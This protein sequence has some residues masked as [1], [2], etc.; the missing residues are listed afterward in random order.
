MKPTIRSSVLIGELD[1][2][3]HRPR[4]HLAYAP[5]EDYL[6]SRPLVDFDDETR[7]IR[8]ETDKL[9]K[10]IY[11]SVPHPRTSTPFQLLPYSGNY[12]EKRISPL[13]HNSMVDDILSMS[14]YSEP[15]SRTI[16]RGHLACVSYAGGRGYPRRKHL[17]SDEYRD[18]GDEIRTRS[19]YNNNYNRAYVDAMSLPTGFASYLLRIKP[20]EKN[21]LTNLEKMHL[22]ALSEERKKNAQNTKSVDDLITEKIR[23]RPAQ[24]AY[25]RSS[26]SIPLL[27]ETT[28]PSSVTKT[29]K[30]EYTKE[31]PKEEIKKEQP[32]YETQTAVPEVYKD[33]NLLNSENISRNT[34]PDTSSLIENKEAEVEYEKPVDPPKP[35]KKEKKPKKSILSKTPSVSDS[36]PPPAEEIKLKSEEITPS[37]ETPVENSKLEETPIPA[38][39]LEPDVE[40]A[41]VEQIEIEPKEPEATKSEI[42]DQEQEQIASLVES[43]TANESQP[44]QAETIT[45]ETPIT[46]TVSAQEETKAE[47]TTEETEPVDSQE[48]PDITVP[49]KIDEPD[50]QPPESLPEKVEE[51]ATEETQ[52]QLDQSES[53]EI[54]Q[55]ARL[56]NT[57]L[58][59]ASDTTIDAEKEQ[60]EN[61]PEHS[62]QSDL[63]QAPEEIIETTPAPAPEAADTETTPAETSTFSE[64][65]SEK[66][67]AKDEPKGE[68]N[69]T[70]LRHSESNEIQ[71]VIEDVTDLGTC[72]AQKEN[73]SEPLIEEPQ[74]PD[75]L[76]NPPEKESS[77][78]ITEVLSDVAEES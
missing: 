74:S 27:R 73:E 34:E 40:P 49:D 35:E 25:Q 12:T 39:D 5:L 1:R 67:E 29:R 72:D 23:D 48:N 44:S 24:K 41:K 54:L 37:E 55:E 38:K 42:A 78:V 64:T 56:D 16:G 47:I 31:E 45:E 13:G 61:I 69:E 58:A 18:I 30:D 28:K 7:L 70:S 17:F 52:P 71:N 77:N 51:V 57:D 10:R 60:T 32:K 36:V 43:P 76:E 22:I 11:T 20:P 66:P 63:K 21:G 6:N 19:Y 3:Y 62:S 33:E 65:I 75:S 59:E 2:I 50:T 14:Y 46:E 53:T 26:T 68:E 15:S 9:M 4:P 8:A